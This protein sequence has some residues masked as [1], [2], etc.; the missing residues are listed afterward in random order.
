MVYSQG[1][2][3][4]TSGYSSSPRNHCSVDRFLRRQFHDDEFNS[5][6][7]KH[8]GY[9]YVGRPDGVCGGHGGSQ[10]LHWRNF[11]SNG[12]QGGPVG[13]AV[14]LSMDISVAVDTRFLAVNA[15]LCV[16][17]GVL[18]GLAPAFRSTRMSLVESLTGRGADASNGGVF[19]PGRLLVVSQVAVSLILLVGSGLFLRTLNNLAGN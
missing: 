13:N 15:A 14:P 17:T 16:S 1:F 9:S 7:A 18:V 8:H 3:P 4:Q 6:N 19:R 10:H 2:C 5:S 11:Y 12:I